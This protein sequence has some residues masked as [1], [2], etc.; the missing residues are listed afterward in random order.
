VKNPLTPIKLA[1]ERLQRRF[2]GRLGEDDKIFDECTQIIIN[3]VDELKNL[4]NEFSRFARLPQLT[5][6]PQ[7]LNGLVQETLVLFQ[8]V[9][10]RITLEFHPD[11]GLPPVLLDREQVKRMLLN[12]L[13]NALASMP[14]GGTITVSLKGDLAQERVELIVADTGVGVA[15]RDKIRIFEPY[16][17]TKRGGTGLGLAIVNSIVAEHQ[18]F[19]RVEDN[20]PEGTK[21]IIDIPMRRAEYVG[22]AAGS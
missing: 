14:G 21:F 19:L 8:E 2:N 4:V 17:S 5:L 7:D 11:S 10:P 6:A 15:D 16:F 12:L 1:A 22:N 3:Q 9:Q 18:G 13:D 20:A